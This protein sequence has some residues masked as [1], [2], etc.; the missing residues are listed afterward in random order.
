[1]SLLEED[2]EVEV[3]LEDAVWCTVIDT[4][5]EA[6]PQPQVVHHPEGE[7]GTIFMKISLLHNYSY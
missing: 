2:P 7:D 5:D 3:F 6:Y 4:N 1:V